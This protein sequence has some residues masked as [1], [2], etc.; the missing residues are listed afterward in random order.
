MPSPDLHLLFSA[1]YCSW[2]FL[3]NRGSPESS[4]LGFDFRQDRV[5]V[6]F[7]IYGEIYL[8]Y[9]ICIIIKDV[10]LGLFSLKALR[11]NLY[12]ILTVSHRNVASVS[13]LIAVR[14]ICFL[15]SHTCPGYIGSFPMI[16]TNHLP[17]KRVTFMVVSYRCYRDK[18]AIILLFLYPIANTTYT[19]IHIRTYCVSAIQRV[20][21]HSLVCQEFRVRWKR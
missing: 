10:L 19:Y 14:I 17:R 20:S 7:F 6:L 1:L 12:S 3:R 13:N 16:Y 18:R 9:I 5:Y 2:G 21:G 11:S 8:E 15:W 4:G